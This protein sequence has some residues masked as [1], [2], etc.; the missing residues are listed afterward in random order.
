MDYNQTIPVYDFDHK[1][2]GLH[3]MAS[4]DDPFNPLQ[5]YRHCDD[6]SVK[7]GYRSKH[8]I[9]NIQLTLF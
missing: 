4:I 3:G 6:T 1:V 8:N 7:C 2:C 9:N 5:V